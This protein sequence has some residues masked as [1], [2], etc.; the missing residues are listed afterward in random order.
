MMFLIAVSMPALAQAEETALRLALR[1]R[2]ATPD[3]IVRFAKALRIWSVLRPYL[4]SVVADD[5]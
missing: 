5:T 2:K 4:E 3:D 1:S